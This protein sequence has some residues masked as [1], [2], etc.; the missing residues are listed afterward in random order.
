[1]KRV[2]RNFDDRYSCYLPKWVYNKYMKMREAYL[3]EAI[4]AIELMKKKVGR[5]L[6]VENQ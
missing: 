6:E 3:D 4:E 5:T 1:M 2:Y